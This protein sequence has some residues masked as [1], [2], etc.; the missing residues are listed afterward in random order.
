MV[1]DIVNLQAATSTENLRALEEVKDFYTTDL[2]R[3]GKKRWTYHMLAEAALNVELHRMSNATSST[4]VDSVT[5]Q[6]C[7]AYADLNQDR[8]SIEEWELPGGVWQFTAIY[9]GAL[10]S[11]R[12]SYV[13]P[14]RTNG[15]I[16]VGHC[17]HDT[18]NY[19]HERLPSIV[20]TSLQ[21]LLQRVPI[22]SLKPEFVSEVLCS[23]VRHLDQAILSELLDFLPHDHLTQ[24]SDT[25][26]DQHIS[27]HYSEWN[28]I[29][30][31]CTQ[32]STVLL[33]LSDPL[34]KNIWILNLGDSIAVLGSRSLS[35]K[36]SATIVNSVHNCNNRSESQRIQQEHP[37]EQACVCDNRVLGYLAPTRALG[38]TWLKVPSVYTRRAFAPHLQDWLS[39]RQ[40]AQYASRILTPPYISELPEVY[41]HSLDISQHE[42]L[43][44]LSS[45]GL[46]DLYDN[47]D[48]QL[49]DQ[50][51]ADHW[52][53]LVGHHMHSTT[54]MEMQS[55]L[56]L[57]LL[58][59]AVGGDNTELV[60]RNL[61]LEM[62]D[63]WMDDVTILV[64]RFQ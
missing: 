38:D 54:D 17:G 52:V 16:F 24:M 33:A 39:P 20:R 21:A 35:G 53:G 2:G 30:T 45:D 15:Q 37:L 62:E 25:Q 8:Y 11:L 27:H 26:V 3:G 43:L 10:N 55:N 18:V 13:F 7:A 59:D 61:T 64:Q 4:F 58:R 9:D 32:G 34:K 56:A 41:H 46:Q 19:V 29:S 36:W 22:T 47:N 60:S 50:E 42:L 1:Y 51:M 49:S 6:P 5:F 23:A 28:A 48:I 31:L 63:K 12:T 14:C 40:V 44:I 57:R